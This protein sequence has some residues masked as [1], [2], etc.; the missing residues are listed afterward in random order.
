MSAPPRPPKEK[1][2]DIHEAI[3]DAETRPLDFPAK[4]RAEYVRKMV[5]KV[6]ELK[7]AGRSTDD[8]ETELPEFK[9]DHPHL[10]EMMTSPEGYDASMLEMMLSMLDKMGDGQVN[11][12]RAS[13]AIGQRLSQT[14]LPQ[15]PGKKE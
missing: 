4:E 13:V 9:R 14:Y 6:Q 10:F 5:R 7:T 2:P 3:K 11:H 15:A 1:G 8:I 12:H